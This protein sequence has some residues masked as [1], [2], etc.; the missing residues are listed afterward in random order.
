MAKILCEETA[1]VILEIEAASID[2][3]H[4]ESF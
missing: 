2:V 4:P 1:T 3:F